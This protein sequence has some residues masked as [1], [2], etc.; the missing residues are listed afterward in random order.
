MIWLYQVVFVV[1]SLVAEYEFCLLLLENPSSPNYLAIAKE[2]I[3]I[4]EMKKLDFQFI[5]ISIE[6]C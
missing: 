3:E 4:D 6:S 5:A 2:V 1:L